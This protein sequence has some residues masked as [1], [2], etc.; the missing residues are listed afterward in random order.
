[1]GEAVVLAILPMLIGIR[2]LFYIS[3]QFFTVLFSFYLVSIGVLVVVR[4]L[5]YRLVGPT[6]PTFGAGAKGL[7]F[8][9]RYP[10]LR[11]AAVVGGLLLIFGLLL[12]PATNLE[13]QRRVHVAELEL[14]QM[15]LTPEE[16]DIGLA[17]NFRQVPVGDKALELV[18]K[19]PDLKMLVLTGESMTD[20]RLAKV[21]EM[22]SLEV[23]WLMNA[24]VT[25]DG[26]LQLAKLPNL[27]RV[28]LG[29]P[30]MTEEGIAKLKER[31]PEVVFEQ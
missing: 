13:A 14:R 23:V 31:L 16:K 22:K 5:G 12:V 27:K 17:I 1:V 15:G 24:Q 25:D 2:P 4:T 20:S 10:N 19:L 30:R 9:L 26:L 18:A 11:F 7:R 21:S 28:A 8:Q 29:G 3:R 6:D